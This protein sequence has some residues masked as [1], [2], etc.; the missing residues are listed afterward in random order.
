LESTS[1]QENVSR[2]WLFLHIQAADQLLVNIKEIVFSVTKEGMA[3]ESQDIIK[4][5]RV[6]S[7]LSARD[8]F[9]PSL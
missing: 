1:G 3:V 4:E 9:S 5:L 2:T 7:Y 8:M 6:A